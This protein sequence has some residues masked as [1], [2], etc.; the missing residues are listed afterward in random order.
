MRTTVLTPTSALTASYVTEIKEKHVHRGKRFLYAEDLPPWE[1]HNASILALAQRTSQRTTVLHA[2]S[3]LAGALVWGVPSY[4]LPLRLDVIY[5]DDKHHGVS[6]VGEQKG[7]GGIP[8]HRTGR[9]Y[10][11][12]SVVEMQGIP[13]LDYPFLIIEF[14]KL[15]DPKQALVTADSLVRQVLGVNHIL[16]ESQLTELENLKHE[17]VQLAT[18][19]LSAREAARIRRRVSYVN[20]LA[21]S[22]LETIVR[23][24]LMRVGVVGLVAQYPFISEGGQYYADLCLPANRVVIECDGQEKYVLDADKTKEAY[25]QKIIENQGFKVVRVSWQQTQR[26]SYVYELLRAMAVEELSRKW[27]W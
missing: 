7:R 26:F 24:D 13:V 25:R 12:E 21:E 23:V 15:D 8:V 5:F 20:P 10:P 4:K 3:L 11:P 14:L 6:K 19:Y 1:V 16:T 18:T 17:L 22:P 9:H 27:K 2:F